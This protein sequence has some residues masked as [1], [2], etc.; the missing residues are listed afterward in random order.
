MLANHC[1]TK[2]MHDGRFVNAKRGDVITS[3]VKLSERWG[4][5]R[6]KVSLFLENLELDEMI[7]RKTD[8]KKTALTICNYCD[9]QDSGTAE[10][11]Q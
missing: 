10:K 4:W 6:S 1:D 9:W 8:I 2:I 7:V 11:Q 5:S 3:T